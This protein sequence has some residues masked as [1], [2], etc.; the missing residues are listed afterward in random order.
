M[1]HK[2]EASSAGLK[3]TIDNTK[4]ANHLELAVD[5]VTKLTVTPEGLIGDFGT[6]G[7]GGGSTGPAFIANQPVSQSVGVG[8]NTKVTLVENYDS[9]NC[10]TNSRFTPNVAGVYQFNFRASINFN[11]VSG[12]TTTAWLFKNGNFFAKGSVSFTSNTSSQT[13]GS[14]GSA[15]AVA[16]GTTDYFELY[17][18]HSFNSPQNTAQPNASNNNGECV[19]SGHFARSI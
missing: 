16:N 19:F 15:Q 8:T 17:V 3:Q 7:G 12:V 2:L 5:G 11:G 18:T 10:F 1:S 13:I 9:D 14:N 4:P 6:G